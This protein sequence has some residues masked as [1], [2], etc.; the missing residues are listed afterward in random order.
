MISSDDIKREALRLG[1]ADCGI[2]QA[3][4]LQEDAKFLRDWLDK[5]FNASMRYMQNY[6]DKRTNPKL[7]VENAKSVIVV[8]LN[9]LPQQTQPQHV[10]QIAKYAYGEDYHFVIKSKLRKLQQFIDE[11]AEHECQI[12]CDSAPVLERRWAER[13]GLGWIGKSGMLIHPKLGSYTFIGEIITTLPLDYDVPQNNRCGTCEECLKAC[14]TN[15]LIAPN[16]LDARRCISYQTIENRSEIPAEL[17]SACGNRLFGC[18]ACIDICP[19]NKKAL[20]TGEKIAVNDEILNI[21]W[22]NFSRADFNR[23][24]KNTPLQR[25]GYKKIKARLEQILQTTQNSPII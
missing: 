16:R 6:F 5:N 20:K 22:E 10:P 4:D 17:L 2:A 1:F 24:F 23:L 18:D 8:L 25:A 11:N 7:L 14:P 15:A 19:W 12:C 3:T 13:A 9:Y 21:D